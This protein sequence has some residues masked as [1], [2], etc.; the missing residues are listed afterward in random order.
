M[1]RVGW[2]RRGKGDGEEEMSRYFASVVG[3]VFSVDLRA[4]ALLSLGVG[5]GLGRGTVSRYFCCCW[6]E[7]LVF[8]FDLSVSALSSPS[9]V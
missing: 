9:M 8:G 1:G 5:R 2:N 4:E 3:I 7:G 6:L